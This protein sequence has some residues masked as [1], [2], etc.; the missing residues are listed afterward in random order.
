MTQPI[1]QVDA[2]TAEPFAGNPA[3]VC[4]LPEE[5]DA[6]WMQH[7]AAE[8][9]LSETAFLVRRPGGD[10]FDLRWF[11]PAVEVDAV[12][13]R[14]ARERA[15]A[16]GGW[17]ARAGRGGPVPHEERRAHRGAAGRLDRAGL[18]GH[19][20]DSRTGARRPGVRAR[21]EGAVRRQEPL[22]LPRRGS[23]TRT[24][25][26]RCSPTTA[27][28]DRCR[29]AAS[30]SRAARRLP[31]VDFVSRFFA[32]ASGIDEDP[33][34]GSAH[35]CLTPYWAAKLGKTAFVARQLSRA[36]RHRCA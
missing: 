26:V 11:T 34:T 12:R 22:R 14:D 10:G 25:S 31:G 4:I 1:A 2:F 30:W 29:S 5:R 28:C 16:V 24:S 33:V 35:C 6:G 15:Y 19:T 23:T 9:N 17:R 32:P 21:C 7:V 8:M 13:P 36:R 27:G 20:S 18:P 3:A